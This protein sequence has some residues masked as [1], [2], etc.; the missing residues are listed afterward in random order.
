MRS[1]WVCRVCIRVRQR[2]RRVVRAV[3]HNHGGAE[4]QM[5]PCGRH[6]RPVVGKHTRTEW[7]ADSRAVMMINGA[8][9]R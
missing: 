7:L 2:D 6:S 1:E 3:A 4:C 9:S 8:A 5:F